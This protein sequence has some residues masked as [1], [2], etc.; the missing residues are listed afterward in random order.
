MVLDFNRSLEIWSFFL[1][2][3]VIT[4]VAD[5]VSLVMAY[6]ISFSEIV[7]PFSKFSIKSGDNRA[8]CQVI[9]NHDSDLPLVTVGLNTNG[10]LYGIIKSRV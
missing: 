5:K 6:L 9:F 2:L 3:A 10:F 4:K 7:N 8:I 1:N